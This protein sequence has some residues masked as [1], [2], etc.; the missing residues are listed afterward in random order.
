VDATIKADVPL[1]PTSEAG[2]MHPFIKLFVPKKG[3]EKKVQ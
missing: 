1:A 3:E 2:H